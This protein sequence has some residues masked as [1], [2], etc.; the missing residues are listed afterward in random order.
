MSLENPNKS[1]KVCA[2]GVQIGGYKVRNLMKK[3][4]L[5]VI[6][7]VAY[8]VTTKRKYSD[9]VNWSPDQNAP[10]LSGGAF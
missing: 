9:L 10:P 4:K 5:K 7:G 1:F 6:Q 8:N 2:I 3:L